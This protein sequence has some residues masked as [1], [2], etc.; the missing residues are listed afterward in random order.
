M[1]FSR[2]RLITFPAFLIPLLAVVVLLSGC[3]WDS[4]SDGNTWNDAYSWV[5]FSGIYRGVNGALIKDYTPGGPSVNPPTVNPGDD[6][7]IVVNNEDAGTAYSLQTV[8]T[9]LLDNRPGIVDGSVTLIFKDIA[10]GVDSG[11]VT[12]SGGVLS[13][14]VNLV[15]PDDATA[16]PATGT[17][18]YDT[19]AWTLTL[20]SPGLLSARNIIANYVYNVAVVQPP[21][22]EPDD[23]SDPSNPW[24]DIFTMRVDQLGNKLS[25]IDSKNG[26]YEGVLTA[27]SNTGGDS[28]GRTGGQIEALFEVN[29]S[30]SDGRPITITGSFTG[31]YIAPGE[32]SDSTTGNARAT[33]FLNNRVVQAMWVEQNDGSTAEMLGQAIAISVELAQENADIVAT[34]TGT[35]EDEAP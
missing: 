18:N 33:G 21:S 4:S 13:G 17:I 25:F 5:N 11:S 19:G 24:D 30:T 20:T 6:I 31:L 10:S 29:G 23:P 12:D 14:F 16:Q 22:P 2:P 28:T 7:L 32:D 34:G 15:G 35:G 1:K 8:L 27:V 3:E 9:G 26:R